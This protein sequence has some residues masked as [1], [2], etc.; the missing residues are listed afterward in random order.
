MKS[1]ITL[2][3]LLL[4]LLGF[5][6]GQDL[7]RLEDAISIALEN[8]HGIM[9]ARNDA[10]ISANNAHRGAA[11]LLPT[12]AANAGGNY[13]VN[14]TKVEFNTNQIPPVDVQGAQSSSL[15]A[16]INVNYTVFDGMGNVNT[17]RVL[18]K[19]A[20]LSE[21]QTQAIIEATISQVA[22]AYYSI[23]RLQE[24]YRTLGESATI[25]QERLTR[26]QNRQAFGGANKLAVLNAEVDLNTDSA[27]LAV[28][29]Y[30]LENV[31]RSL[32][33]LLGRDINSSFN[34]NTEVAFSQSMKLP[35]LMAQAQANNVQLR[36]AAYGQQIAELNLK[37]AKSN[38]MP[39]LGVSAGYN[40]NKADNGPGSILK[41]QE[42]LGLALGA[43]LSIPIFAGN[44]RKVAVQNAE[45]DLLNSQHQQN[46]AKLNLERDL[47]N[48]FYTFQSTLRQYELQQKSLESAQENFNRTQDAF[49]LGQATNVQFRE[50]QLNLQRVQDRIN[51]LRYTAKLN[52]I[53]VLRLSGQ[54]VK[55]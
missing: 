4:G 13:N 10:Q 38:Y 55:E 17:F 32:N 50:A 40:Y 2:S 26:S 20:A 21:T 46:E 34:V 24:S 1:Y 22:A 41:T 42:N 31:K 29:F 12:V 19:S 49:E 15:N 25:S 14:N 45:I 35:D 37:I 8:N 7:L 43:T 47:A 9:V 6:T 16:G 48:A 51:D 11:G 53:E 28:A 3:L 5:S 52:E 54:L 30:N 18:Q 39:V 36:L 23:A 27:N 44:Q 33:A